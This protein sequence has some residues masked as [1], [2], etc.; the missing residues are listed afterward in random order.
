MEHEDMYF[1]V[2]QH[3]ISIDDAGTPVMYDMNQDGTVDW[4]SQDLIDWL[5]LNPDQYQLY[6]A[7]VDFLQVYAPHPMYIK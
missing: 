7:C 6:K 1:V 2:G 3:A 5:D 4:E